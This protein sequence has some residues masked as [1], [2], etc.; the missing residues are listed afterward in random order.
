[1]RRVCPGCGFIFFNDPKVACG[2]L[3][4]HGGQVLLVR[5]AVEPKQGDWAL[6]A[7]FMEIDEGPVAAAMR[8]CREETGLIVRVTGLV[9]VYPITGDPGRR[10]VLIIYRATP[11]GGRLQA[12]DDALEVQFFGPEALPENIAFLSTRRALLRW[13]LEKS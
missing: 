2:V 6:P 11:E 4:A 9:G 1:M 8:E 13:R 5:R 10:G 3:V 12:G 7:G